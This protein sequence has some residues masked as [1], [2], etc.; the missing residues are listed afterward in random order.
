MVI[1]VFYVEKIDIVVVVDTAELKRLDVVE[2]VENCHVLSSY[3]HK[4]TWVEK[5]LNY[6]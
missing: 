1:V 4:E 2:E 6:R 5:V 3:G